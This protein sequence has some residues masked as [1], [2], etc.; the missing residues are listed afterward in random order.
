MPKSLFKGAVKRIVL[1]DMALSSFDKD[2]KTIC[3]HKAATLFARMRRYANGERLAFKYEYNHEG[4]RYF[5]IK[6]QEPA[7]LRAY[8]W[9]ERH[10]EQL[11]VVT[12]FNIKSTQL[13]TEE[14]KQIMREQYDIFCRN[15]CDYDD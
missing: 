8:F 3:G 10:Y 4:Y 2:T 9:D 5:A 13:L 11:M 12:H 14:D 1:T 7:S 6:Q 15:G